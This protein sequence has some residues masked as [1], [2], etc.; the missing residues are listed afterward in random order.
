MHFCLDKEAPEQLRMGLYKFMPSTSVTH[1]ST[2]VSCEA[3]FSLCVKSE[4]V[5]FW[6]K[7]YVA[8]VSHVYVKNVL[9]QRMSIVY[10]LNS[11]YA[12]SCI[13]THNWTNC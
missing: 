5:L 10:P 3:S 2:D 8:P 1:D 13:Y 4:K 9:R 11:R 6:A 12:V 7:F